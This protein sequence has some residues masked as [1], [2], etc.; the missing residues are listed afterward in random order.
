MCPLGSCQEIHNCTAA[1]RRGSFPESGIAVCYIA[2]VVCDLG[3]PKFFFAT[4]PNLRTD[5]AGNHH[6]IA[7]RIISEAK[8][9]Q[10]GSGYENHPTRS[11]SG[12][13]DRVPMAGYRGHCRK[14]PKITMKIPNWV[15]GIGT[16]PHGTLVNV[17]ASNSA[18]ISWFF[19]G[20]YGK[21]SH[22]NESAADQ[23]SA[24]LL[25]SKR[26][27]ASTWRLDST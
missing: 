15:R 26:H 1:G 11:R 16:W 22:S 27:E 23:Q 9:L 18:Y 8:K 25:H 13:R 21:Y 7:S 6:R 2:V 17:H 10:E 14:T 19:W 20:P 3:V 24:F 5:S 12:G 4:P